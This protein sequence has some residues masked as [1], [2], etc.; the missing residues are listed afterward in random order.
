LDKNRVEIMEI[1]LSIIDKNKENNNRSKESA[2]TTARRI[3]RNEPGR[4]AASLCN[5]QLP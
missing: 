3:R 4:C 1:F 5:W 2:E